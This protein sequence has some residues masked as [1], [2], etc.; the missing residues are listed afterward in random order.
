MKR[1]KDCKAVI[2][3]TFGDNEPLKRVSKASVKENL[4]LEC[5]EKKN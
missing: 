1:C 4:C 2:S 5:Y 3:L